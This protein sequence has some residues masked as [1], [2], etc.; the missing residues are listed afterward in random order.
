MT[1]LFGIA[2]ENGFAQ[3][4]SPR[5]PEEL[6]M[7][8]IGFCRTGQGEF[9]DLNRVLFLENRSVTPS[10]GEARRIRVDG[11]VLSIERL[12]SSPRTYTYSI[13]DEINETAPPDVDL[14]LVIVDGELAV[15]WRE[16]F[17]H[18]Q[19]RQGIFRIVG[20]RISPWCEGLGGSG[21]EN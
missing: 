20:E 14:K 16:T 3:A 17:R 5:Q 7:T 12:S 10:H 15:Y 4:G 21:A 8:D 13:D 19:Y 11:E 6:V 1:L 9:L 18:T 2:V